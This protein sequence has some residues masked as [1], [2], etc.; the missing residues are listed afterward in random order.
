MQLSIDLAYRTGCSLTFLCQ[1]MNHI[2]L[3]TCTMPAIPQCSSSWLKDWLYLQQIEFYLPSLVLLCDSAILLPF[4][5]RGPVKHNRLNS[6]EQLEYWCLY[7]FCNRTL[8]WLGNFIYLFIYLATAVLS[9]DRWHACRKKINKC[10]MFGAAVQ[11][12]TA[13]QYKF[14]S[15]CESHM[16]LW[17]SGM[18]L[19]L[20]IMF[21]ALSQCLRA[22]D[23]QFLI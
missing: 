9:T 15:K 16:D 20:L 6:Q 17:T 5:S 7:P 1:C 8:F 19:Q 23:I 10:K 4:P 21:I 13:Q 2:T 18:K 14:T 11:Q 22:P 3:C 12:L